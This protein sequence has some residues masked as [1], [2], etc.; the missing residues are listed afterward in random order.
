M[1]HLSRLPVHTV[2]ADLA[3]APARGPTEVGP[4]L[5]VPGSLS[6]V[7]FPNRFPEG[8]PDIRS[9]DEQEWL[10][11]PQKSGQGSVRESNGGVEAV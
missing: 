8:T 9:G 5:G 4:P 7:V 6:H 2:G 1:P 10:K 3:S 11:R